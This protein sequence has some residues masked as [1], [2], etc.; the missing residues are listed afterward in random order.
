M[1]VR[2]RRVYICGFVYVSSPDSCRASVRVL[3]ESQVTAS[4][5]E[6]KVQW[7]NMYPLLDVLIAVVFKNKNVC[8]QGV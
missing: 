4:V 1:R 5:I 2:A 8:A 7:P 6:V 3:F